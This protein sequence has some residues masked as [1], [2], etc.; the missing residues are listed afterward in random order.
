MRTGALLL[1]GD[2]MLKL[3]RRKMWWMASVRREVLA[4]SIEICYACKT[5]SITPLH[6]RSGLRRCCPTIWVL[7][8][9]RRGTEVLLEIGYAEEGSA[10]NPIRHRRL[11]CSRL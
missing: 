10:L 2:K 7:L 4:R 8:N 11:T 6:Q 1:L 3:R 9:E 5:Q